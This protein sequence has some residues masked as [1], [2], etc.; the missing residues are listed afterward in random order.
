MAREIEEIKSLIVIA[1]L[2]PFSYIL[3]LLLSYLCS[4]PL[5]QIYAISACV[6]I[7]TLLAI[8]IIFRRLWKSL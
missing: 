4:N 7:G 8:A 5:T 1:G 3:G 2:V 6:L